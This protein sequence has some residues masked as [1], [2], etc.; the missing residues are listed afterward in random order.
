MLKNK[1]DLNTEIRPCNKKT[2][3]QYNIFISDDSFD[4]FA[5]IVSPYMIGCMKYKIPGEH[6]R[7]HWRQ[8]IE[9]KIDKDT[10]NRL[11]NQ[12]LFTQE[13]IAKIFNVRK[14]TIRKY[15]DL[16]NIAPR[17]II[18]AQMNGKN[19]K[20][21]R[22]NSGQ[23]LPLQINEDQEKR[24][25]DVFKEI[26]LAKFPY[27]PIKQEN[28]YIGILDRLYSSN[29]LANT[30][31]IVDTYSRSGIDICSAYCPQ[32]FSMAAE[33]SLSPI[34]IYN[35]DNMFMD[36]IR[37]TIK[38]TRNNSHAAIRQGLKT[39][40]RNRCVT[41]FPPMWAKSIIKQYCNG[42]NL[43]VLDFSC[44]FGGRLI[45]CYA[46][47]LVNKYMGI[48]PLCENI[49]SNI[50]IYNIIKRHSD[51]K[52]IKFEAKF[53]KEPA[54]VALP[55]INDKFDIIITSP[56]Y[57]TKEQYSK[58]ITQ[59]YIKYNNYNMWKEE[60][61]NKTL[62]A[63]YE[64]LN[65]NGHMF[66]FASNYDKYN[67]GFDCRDILRYI[68]KSEPLCVNFRLPSLEYFRS[69]NLKKYDT[70]WIVQ[71]NNSPKDISLFS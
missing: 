18:L 49:D 54:E 9:C 40:R 38:Y 69:K 41:I 6:N 20:C 11:Y 23:F 24:A 14:G 63:T 51:L 5:E 35:D 4:R 25:Q 22:S 46:S 28:Y 62:I 48:D 21:N 34:D 36:C 56:P 50:K 60:W 37:Q 67:I 17:D 47:S 68:S 1:F 59:C 13:Q 31:N 12:E 2:G 52:N 64:K 19:N 61:L 58:E 29:I 27:V 55:L 45:G 65:E 66:I 42:G 8:N 70:A 10:L 43:S 3:M 71:K 33:G 7:L 53:I 32:I 39:Y 57:F 26:K 16:F 30:N 15:M 44:G